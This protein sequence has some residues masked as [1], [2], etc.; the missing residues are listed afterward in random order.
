M[1]PIEPKRTENSRDKK[2]PYIQ[3]IKLEEI[4]KRF[5]ESI[6]EIKAQ[7]EIAQTLVDNNLH[8]ADNIW[9]AQVFFL[10]SALDFYIHEITKY[11]IIRIINSKQEAH[12]EFKKFKI[13]IDFL[14]RV[15]HNSENI[16]NI[17]KEVNET[18]RYSTYMRFDS[19]KEQLDIIGVKVRNIENYRYVINDISDR[20]NQIAHSSDRDHRG[21]K[22]AIDK[23]TV[24][25]YVTKLAEFQK[26]IHEAINGQEEN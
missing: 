20:R 8:G 16:N 26:A 1:S 14:K 23:E 19:I 9:R 10:D 2:I 5:D 13:S 12:R 22:V 3:N 18:I 11:G 25:N 21:K 17:L 15:Y 4:Q 24:S 6:S 7:F